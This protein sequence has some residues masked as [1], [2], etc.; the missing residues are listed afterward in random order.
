MHVRKGDTV[1]VITGKDKGKRG[2]VLRI[3]SATGRVVVERIAMVKRHTKPTQRNPRGGIL[4]KEGTL[5]ASNVALWCGKCGAGRRCRADI[6]E[7]Q[8]KRRVCVKCGS[9]I[10]SA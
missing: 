8:K 9:A 3:L 1:V 6:K 4:E 5:E 2:R 7:G 10:E